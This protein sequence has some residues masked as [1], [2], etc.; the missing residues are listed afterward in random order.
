MALYPQFCKQNVA[1][2]RRREVQAVHAEM[3]TRKP[4][5]VEDVEKNS[6]VRITKMRPLNGRM[7]RDYPVVHLTVTE[8]KLSSRAFAAT[9]FQW[10]TLKNKDA[11]LSA[12]A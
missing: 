3:Q 2:R 5:H 9:V 4:L 6:S 10:K 8:Q 12:N 1:E 7:H 11:A